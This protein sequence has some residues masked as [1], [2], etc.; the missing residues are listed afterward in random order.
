MDVDGLNTMLINIKIV[1]EDYI[2]Y[3]MMEPSYSTDE[4]NAM[5]PEE[6]EAAIKEHWESKL[7]VTAIKNTK[8]V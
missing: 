6:K 2:L 8:L 4:W 3:F 5:S 1:V 7:G